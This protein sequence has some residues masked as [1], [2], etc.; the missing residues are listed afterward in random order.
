MSYS[1]KIR[2]ERAEKNS[3]GNLRAKINNESY[4]GH[5]NTKKEAIQW[6]CKHGIDLELMFNR[7]LQLVNSR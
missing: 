4:T 2:S 5:F 1:Y 7:K 6:Y 3:N